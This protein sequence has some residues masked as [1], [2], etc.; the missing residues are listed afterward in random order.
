[1]RGYTNTGD[2]VPLFD[3]GAVIANPNSALGVWDWGSSPLGVNSFAYGGGTYGTVWFAIQ[4]V[5]KLLIDIVDTNNASAYV[6]AG[7]LV[8]G[9]YWSPDRNPSYGAQ[10]S[11]TGTS[12]HE[13]NDSGDLM[14]AR[15]AK[16]RK[17]TLPMN[18]MTPADR[19]KLW[20]ILRSNGMSK[21]MLVSLFPESADPDLEQAHQLYGKLSQI[22]AI[23]VSNYSGYSSTLALEEV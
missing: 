4:P 17:M 6:E 21:P 2:S 3:T 9:T 20:N 13:R 11:V 22:S 15:G 7:R 1:V 16:Y 8:A 10:P 5:R 23:T 18:D 14:T 12:K 19:A